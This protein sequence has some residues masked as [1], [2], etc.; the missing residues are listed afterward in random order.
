M[1]IGGCLG[2]IFRRTL[3]GLDVVAE[4]LFVLNAVVDDPVGEE[5]KV[6]GER[7]GPGAGDC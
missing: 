3:R 2:E 6:G 5:E 7:E 1:A 4:V